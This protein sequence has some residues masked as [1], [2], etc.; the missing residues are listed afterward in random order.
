MNVSYLCIQVSLLTF[1]N[2]FLE[3]K[4][5]LMFSEFDLC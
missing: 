2:T 5:K 4:W 3:V 1:L